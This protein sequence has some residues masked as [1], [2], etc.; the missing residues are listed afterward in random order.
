MIEPTSSRRASLVISNADIGQPVETEQKSKVCRVG[1]VLASPITIGLN[2]ALSA[3]LIAGG[4]ALLATGVGG[5][6]GLGL[7]IGGIGVAT[8]ASVGGVLRGIAN[9]K[10]KQSREAS[11]PIEE[12]ERQ[13]DIIQP[14]EMETASGVYRQEIQTKK[15]YIR[16]NQV[17]ANPQGVISLASDIH[18]SVSLNFMR[19][20][21][22]EIKFIGFSR[23]GLSVEAA[24]EKYQAFTE[25][26]ETDVDDNI[27]V[28]EYGGTKVLMAREEGYVQ[29]IA[30]HASPDR[31]RTAANQQIQN[32]LN[33]DLLHDLGS[34]YP[35]YAISDFHYIARDAGINLC[36]F[37]GENELI[38]DDFKL[39]PDDFKQTLTDLKTMHQRGIFVADISPE[40]FAIKS[41]STA[42]ERRV[43]FIDTDS[44]CHPN[45]RPYTNERASIGIKDGYIQERVKANLENPLY[46]KG[47][48]F[49]AMLITML[50]VTGFHMLSPRL[51]DNNGYAPLDMLNTYQQNFLTTW[52][53][54]E[55]HEVIN[56]MLE[57]P[58]SFIGSKT[59]L[60]EIP[61]LV[62]LINL[63]S[64]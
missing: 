36:N 21:Q 4:A 57:D 56:E 16:A 31:V 3:L 15:E 25:I 8:T 39:S 53:K 17:A 55:H 23:D 63:S 11:S 28:P 45:Y 58:A 43:K 30:H 37:I 12:I 33:L 6:A 32:R 14:Q 18:S 49:Y 48:D 24:K 1:N 5:V 20:A 51:F 64:G 10:S 41:A 9:Y 26:R 13:Q 34:V 52:I 46:Q 62:D 38:P 59:Q 61:E 7:V 44:M 2:V 35:T 50:E 22:G 40:N 42:A 54:P 29:L 47:Q 60:E 19:D 27:Q